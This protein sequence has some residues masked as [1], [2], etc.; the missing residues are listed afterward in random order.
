MVLTYVLALCIISASGN[1]CGALIPQTNFAYLPLEEAHMA[2]KNLAKD[3]P[4]DIR[5]G[6]SV[7]ICVKGYQRDVTYG[8]YR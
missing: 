7:L 4:R 8:T 3:G 5:P 2:C 6:G 1:Q